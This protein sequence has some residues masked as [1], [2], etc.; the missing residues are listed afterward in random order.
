MDGAGSHGHSF[1]HLH[2]LFS[3]KRLARSMLELLVYGQPGHLIRRA[4]QTAWA[5]FME[6]TKGQDI[7]PVQYAALIAIADNPGIDAT[8]LSQLIAFDRATIGNVLD[9]LE[10]KRLLTRV[11]SP[12]DKRAKLTFLTAGGKRTIKIISESVP[13]IAERIFGRLSTRD[14]RTLMALL[15]KLVDIEHAGRSD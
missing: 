3:E 9:R 11:K 12:S 1:G 4:H 8:R 5:A 15:S 10:K 14:R 7:T 13:T 2:Q 6:E